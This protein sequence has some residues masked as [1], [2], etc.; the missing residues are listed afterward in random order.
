MPPLPDG[1]SVAV[2]LLFTNDQAGAV[3]GKGGA[4]IR[5]LQVPF[6]LPKSKTFCFPFVAPCVFV[7][8]VSAV[9]SLRE[10]VVC[11]LCVFVVVADV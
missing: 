6:S 4:E 5:S 1:D 11:L 8:N 3:I 10:S 9:P 2:K 7:W